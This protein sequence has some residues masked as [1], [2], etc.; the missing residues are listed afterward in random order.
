M[1]I[2]TSDLARLDSEV[3]SVATAEGITLTGDFGI[4]RTAVEE[5]AHE[6]T[7][8]MIS[9]G[10]YLMSGDLSSNHIAAVLFTGSSSSVRQKASLQ[11]I[12]VSGD[13]VNQWSPIKQWA[14]FWA[15]KTFYRNA[16][17]RVGG[18]RYS[19]KSEYY[20]SELANRITPGLYSLGLP[21]VARPLSRPGA[22]FERSSGSWGSDNVSFI[23]GS[24]TSTAALE[25]GITFCDMSQSDLYVSATARNNAE[26]EPSALVAVT[27]E[28][29]KV[30]QVDITSLNPPTGV[31][32]ISQR[33]RHPISP[34]TATHWNVYV[35][36]AGGTMYLQNAV[37]IPIATKTYA[38]SGNPTLSGYTSELGQYPDGNLS[39]HPTRQRG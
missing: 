11:Q 21:M 29:A 26:S 12:V 6:L 34:L 32:H 10:G 13:V 25:V 7:K 33:Q 16:A 14:V 22:T 1:F 35:G 39:L 8:L 20:Q 2:S 24:G 30:I 3:S 5:S 23:S 27:H 15:L 28:N 38:L 19:K 17:S 9:F 31:Q 18:D 37:P 36:A 4:L